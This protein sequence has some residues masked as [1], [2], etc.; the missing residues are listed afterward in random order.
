MENNKQQTFKS[1]N[2][3]DSRRKSIRH[4]SAPIRKW[5]RDEERV[6][7]DFLSNTI[8][9]FEKPTAQIYYRKFMAESKIENIEWKL[10]RSKVRNMR[11]VHMKARRWKES[12]AEANNLSDADV[13]DNLLRMCYF[14]DEFE[15]LFGGDTN[16]CEESPS[17]ADESINNDFIK[18]EME[19][20][21]ISDNLELRVS[22]EGDNMLPE[23]EIT[24]QNED[25]QN[26]DNH[27]Q[28]H[29]NKSSNSYN[30]FDDA[31]NY[32]EMKIPLNYINY[33]LREKEL[34]LQ[35]DRLE[36]EKEK[37]RQ[38]MIIRQKEI[39][40]QERLKILELEMKERIA[41]CDIKMKENVA[42]KA[43]D[44]KFDCNEL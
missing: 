44:K 26:E 2:M 39:E 40:S 3:T 28:Q 29:H 35:R 30:D 19:L 42:L 6:L 16:K 22:S 41:M 1:S 12:A 18:E 14:Y 7:I 34:K 11:M 23:P 4:R 13:K 43:L 10:I 32:D 25:E 9:D 37:L 31:E 36:F 38:E 17:T 20:N 15:N 27:H 5:Q 21:D 8:K 33:S 24:L